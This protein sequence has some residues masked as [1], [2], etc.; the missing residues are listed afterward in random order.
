[1]AKLSKK[2]LILIFI[3]LIIIT[4]NYWPM[5]KM[6]MLDFEEEI[7]YSIIGITTNLKDY[8]LSF[9]LNKLSNFQFRRV[10]PFLFKHNGQPFMYSMY[11]F[12]DNTNLRNYYLVANKANAVK[13]VK[14]YQH[15]DYL[16]VMDGEINDD[17]LKDL[18]KR[19]KTCNSVSLTSVIDIYEF[20]KIKNLRTTFDIHLDTVLTNN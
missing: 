2:T 7:N 16:L 20:E 3:K 1:V 4:N 17:F 15:F 9:Y 8:R 10:D 5:S 12:L 19:I 13:L 14:K 18:A 11:I 6:L